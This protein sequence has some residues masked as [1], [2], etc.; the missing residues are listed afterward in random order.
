MMQRQPEGLTIT[1]LAAL[2]AL[3]QPA[4]GQSSGFVD[5]TTV[6]RDLV[7]PEVW[8]GLEAQLGLDSLRDLTLYE[9][10]QEVD[11]LV[12]TFSARL[13]LHYT[14]TT[15]SPLD[16]L[17]LRLPVNASLEAGQ[18]PAEVGWLELRG[19][20]LEAGPPVSLESVR[21][22]LAQLRFGRPVAPGERIVVTLDYE[23]QLRMLR[24]Q[25]NDLFGQALSSLG[26]LT[27]VGE[28][29]YGLLAMADGILTMA[30]AY[31]LVAPYREGGFDVTP[32]GPVGDLVYNHVAAF[33]VRTTMP[34]GM[35]FVSN[36]VDS[37]PFTNPDGTTVT[38]SEGTLVRDF[39]LVAGRDLTAESAWVG[40]TR[41][42][43]VYRAPDARA[44]RLALEVATD[45]LRSFEARFG[46]YPYTELDV[47]E[48]SLV[49]GA[50][51]VEFSG[52]VL[53]AGML[54]RDPR[55]SSSPFG[56]LFQLLDGL[57]TW[58][59]MLDALGGSGTGGLPGL[60]AGG[61]PNV[62]G[63]LDRLLEFTVAHEVAH[64]YF[65]GLV[66]NDA[67]RHP[68][69]DEPLAQYAAGLAYEDRHG[70]AAAEEAMEMNVK[71]SYG[72]Y[73]LLGGVDRPVLRE[74]AAYGSVLEYAGLVYGKAP[75]LYVA[76]RRSLG[77]ARLHGA[78]RDAI[79]AHRFQI[80]STEE[81]IAALE[82]AAGPGSGIR[83]ASRR[84]LEGTDGDVDLGMPDPDVWVLG[85]LTTPELARSLSDGLATLGMRPGD[86]VRTLLGGGLGGA[87]GAPVLGFGIDLQRVLEQLLAP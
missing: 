68:S 55:H 82:A 62:Q 10:D 45:A 43:S 12:G 24:G 16:T 53:I 18:S 1:V 7:R 74:T 59:P 70:A 65:A 42:T 72:V 27:A 75:Y 8:P 76:L 87:P 39:V 3:A 77:D 84:W 36:L 11:D 23:G 5:V 46:D 64:Q 44:G 32:T 47:V 86:L 14:N 51:G 29:D 4:W 80:I 52:M 71:L 49:G 79:A 41:V 21:P 85:R 38:S 26:S 35:A 67:S 48:A 63:M 6:G 61:L 37:A 83:E 34:P 13:R 28:A 17:P 22:T 30:S 81:W 19:A 50:G 9:I 15:G 25:V 56:T 31:P 33:R 69:L 57:S 20:T 73:R 60:G 54:Y 58:A 2:L 66:G 78:M 40:D